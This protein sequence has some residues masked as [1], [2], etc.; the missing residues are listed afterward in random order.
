M[1]EELSY[2]D[3]LFPGFGVAMNAPETEVTHQ[4]PPASL[5]KKV[6]RKDENRL[7]DEEAE[8]SFFSSL[9]AQGEVVQLKETTEPSK[10]KDCTEQLR[11][12]KS[13]RRTK[14]NENYEKDENCPGGEGEENSC[15]SFF[16]SPPQDGPTL[17]LEAMHGPVGE[18]VRLLAPFTEADP[19]AMYVQLLAGLGSIIGP[20][21]H[22]MADGASHRVNLFAVICGKSAKARKGTSWARVKNVLSELDDDW[23]SSRVN[24][25]VVSGEGVTQVF[26]NDKERR[27]LLLETEFGQV[28]QAMKREGNTVSSLLR[29]AWDGTRLAVLRRKDPIQVDGAHISMIGHITVPELHQL[30]SSA[31]I[32]N[33][34]ANR[35]LWVFAKRRQLLPEDGNSPCLAGPLRKLR[36]AITHARSMGRMERDA[37]AAQL[38]RKIYE[39]LSHEQPGQLGD[40]L[41]RGE[42][43]VMRLALLFALLDQSEAIQVVHLEAAYALWKYCEASV[44]RIFG[45]HLLSKRARKIWDALGEKPLT[46]TELYGLFGNNLSKDQLEAAL[47]ELDPLIESLP[48]GTG[49]GRIIRRRPVE[50]AISSVSRKNGK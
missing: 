47:K 25:G 33:G 23:L 24:T 48:S 1:I 21:P 29:Q 7:R 49:G 28:L 38:W 5:R 40:L 14:A 34:M 35:C 11:H 41:S 4:G 36:A 30:L 22:F 19:A 15:I 43:H 16:S 50:E 39:E 9:T 45:E 2:P 17:P 44:I 13:F 27:L 42:A 32:S 8:N 31:D 37:A 20:S 6:K 46:M 3:E 10:P 12:R 18:I 26:E